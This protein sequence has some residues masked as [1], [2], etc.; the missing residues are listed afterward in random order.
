[1]SY[2]KKLNTHYYDGK[3]KERFHEIRESVPKS[4]ELPSLSI[5][6]Q[7]MDV[8]ICSTTNLRTR[9][10]ANKVMRTL[11]ADTGSAKNHDATSDINVDDLIPLVWY[12]VRNYDISG[13]DL[14]IEQ[15]AEIQGGMCPQGRVARLI[16]MVELP[17]KE[18][19]DEQNK[20]KESSR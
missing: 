10:I 5:C 20:G 17:P 13:K 1:M 15:I 2:M 11:E 16:Q 6:Y 18:N 9:R 7:E 12:Y 3:L 4:V 14:F 19:T 8:L